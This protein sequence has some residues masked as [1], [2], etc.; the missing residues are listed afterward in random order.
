MSVFQLVTI[1]LLVLLLGVTAAGVVRRRLA[2]R[3]GIGWML[4]WTASVVA[5]GKP[6][7]L[8]VIAR[9]LGIGRGADLVLYLSIIFVFVAVF[10][11]YLRFKR[12]DDQITKLTRR[13]AIMSVEDEEQ[14]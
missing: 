5:I 8:V 13:I 12:L 3:A 7:L 4:L 11:I 1:P 9:I 10:L 2:P 6:E 14:R